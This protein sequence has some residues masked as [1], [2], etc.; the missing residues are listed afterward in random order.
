MPPDVSG[1][2]RRSEKGMHEQNL[3]KREG[4]SHADIWMR[5]FR[6]VQRL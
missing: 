2:G 1:E 3:Q 5:E 4:V 6:H